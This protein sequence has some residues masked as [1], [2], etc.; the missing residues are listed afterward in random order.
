MEDVHNPF[1]LHLINI[2]H[3]LRVLNLEIFFHPKCV[4]VSGLCNLYLKH[5]SSFIFKLSIMM[6][7]TLK[8]CTFH[9]VHISRF[10]LFFLFF[11]FHFWGLELR[12]DSVKNAKRVSGLFNL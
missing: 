6:V 12:H 9:F 8:M 7:H 5:F 11:F 3:I 10:F 2:C 1:C 4:G